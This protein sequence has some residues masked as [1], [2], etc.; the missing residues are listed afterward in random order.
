[1]ANKAMYKG[2]FLGNQFHGN[3]ILVWSNG[4]IYSGG[5]YN[6]KYHGKGD[7]NWADGIKQYKGDFK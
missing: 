6:G 1:M 4:D 5:F 3:G 7:F 2:N